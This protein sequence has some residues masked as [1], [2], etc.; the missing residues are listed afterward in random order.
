MQTL[1][2]IFSHPERSVATPYIHALAPRLIE[3]L[4]GENAQNV[5]NDN[6]L[7]VTLETIGT[8]E[9]LITLAEPQHRKFCI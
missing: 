3:Y 4:Y 6:E 5:A 8:V 2:S 1:K 9:M 7:A